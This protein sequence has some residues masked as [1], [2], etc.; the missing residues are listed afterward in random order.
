ML[1]LGRFLNGI[2][3]G[4]Y[5]VVTTMYTGE[6]A[7][8]SIRGT[9]GSFFQLL[10]TIGIFFNYVLD[11]LVCQAKFCSQPNYVLKTMHVLM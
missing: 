1:Y 11:A 5:C 6:I 10:I 8:A 4:A 9:L 2:V 7:E 3:T